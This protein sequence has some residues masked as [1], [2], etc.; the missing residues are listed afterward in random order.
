MVGLVSF[1]RRDAD[2]RGH[3]GP[4][5]NEVELSYLFLP[6]A[7]GHGYAT[8]SCAAALDWA[9]QALPCEAVVLCTQTANERSVRLA[10]KLGFHERER[11]E[12]FSAEQWFGVR[13]AVTPAN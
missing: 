11:F 2:R 5:A 8:E 10:A 7:W 1:S 9:D 12:E 3:L 6:S 4:E 13:P